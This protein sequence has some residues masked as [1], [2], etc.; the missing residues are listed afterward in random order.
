MK[1]KTSYSLNMPFIIILLISL[2]FLW[3]SS[4]KKPVEPELIK[5]HPEFL[6]Y[7]YFKDGTYW[8]YQ[9]STSG[10]T[11]SFSV[12]N[13]VILIE[14]GKG[15]RHTPAFKREIF[16]Y[17]LVKNNYDNLYNYTG[18]GYVHV[19]LTLWNLHV[20]LLVTVTRIQR[21]VYLLISFITNPLK[22]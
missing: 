17:E 22:D 8:V 15:G 4:C 5:L 21:K 19:T 12:L 18:G 1:M 14:E 13:S 16:I 9:D 3:A 7:S 10:N 6:E 20:L 11:D 2:P